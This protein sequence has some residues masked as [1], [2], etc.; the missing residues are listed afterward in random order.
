MQPCV[1]NFRIENAVNPRPKDDYDFMI[2]T[3]RCRSEN[4][5]FLVR[6]LLANP[7]KMS[8]AT[9]TVKFCRRGTYN[10]EGVYQASEHAGIPAVMHSVWKNPEG[11]VR[12]LL[13]NWT[14]EE[15]VYRIETPDVVCEGTVPARSWKWR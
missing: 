11:E 15:Q 12:T 2:A 3:A 8:T 6:S 10:A 14:R 4:A 1:H 7:G 9:K 5:K 13:V